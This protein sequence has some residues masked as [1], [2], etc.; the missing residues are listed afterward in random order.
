MRAELV[1][2]A[3][4]VAARNYTLADGAIFHSDRGTQYTSK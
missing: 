1:G 3:L 2:D 4:H